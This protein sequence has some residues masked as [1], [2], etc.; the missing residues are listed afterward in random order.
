MKDLI[1]IT[2]KTFFFLFQ[3]LFSLV[4]H[5]WL[6]M[7]YWNTFDWVDVRLRKKK[8]GQDIETLSIGLDW[9]KK[10]GQDIF[11]TYIY[12][13]GK[14]FSSVQLMLASPQ[15]LKWHDIANSYG[16]REC[17]WKLWNE[18]SG[19]RNTNFSYTMQKLSHKD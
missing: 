6:K 1:N 9:G 18:K 5:H 14:C 16:N 19:C 7:I 3:F 11:K 2:I 8:F 12:F 17:F 4:L 15:A 13:C 10:I